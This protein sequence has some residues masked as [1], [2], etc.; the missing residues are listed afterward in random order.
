MSNTIISY[1]PITLDDNPIISKIIKDVMTSFGCV[2]EGY[3]IEDAEVD[4]MYQAYSDDRSIYYIIEVNDEVV[5]GAGISQLDGADGTICELKKMYF[6][7]KG[8]GYGLGRQLIAQLVSDAKVRGYKTCYLET[9][10]RMEAANH[11][12][13]SFGFT[14]NESS[15]GNTGHCGCDTYYSLD[16]T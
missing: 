5:G 8:R 14:K 9:V 13:A 3:S 4:Q 7:P 12:Y 16:L 6:L 2:G 11:L 1:R 10:Q 15:V